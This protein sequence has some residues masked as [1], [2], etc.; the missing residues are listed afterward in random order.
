M[1]ALC[2]ATVATYF[3]SIILRK[4]K[5]SIVDIANASLAG[6][7]AIGSTC[8]HA[9]HPAA[10]VIGLIAGVLSTFGFAVIQAKLQN[11]LKCID[12]CGVLYLH[13]LPGLMGGIAAVFVVEG[14]N[15]SNQL[16]GIVITIIVAIVAGYITGK[17]LS[18]FGRKAIAYADIDEFTEVEA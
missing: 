12:T 17:V 11:A 2:G 9:N 13:G 18:A 14:I 7:V 3:A 1:L 6:G 8:D 4:G 10:F 5:I 16:K 15:K